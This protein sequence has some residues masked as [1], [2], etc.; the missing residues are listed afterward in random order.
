MAPLKISRL[1]KKSQV[2]FWQCMMRGAQI[3]STRRNGSFS[4]GKKPIEELPLLD[5]LHCDGV[6]ESKGKKRFM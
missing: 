2:A 4:H 1:G 6:P 3:R 5:A